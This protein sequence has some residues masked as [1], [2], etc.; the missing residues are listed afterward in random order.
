MES[1]TTTAT[2]FEAAMSA[3]Q[4]N[5][6]VALKSAGVV[7]RE[8]RKA[9]AAAVTGQV[10]EL[11]RALSGAV[12]QAE[13][14]AGLA[15]Q[16]L[17]SFDFDDADYLASGGYVKELLALAAERAVGLFEEDERLL[18]YPSVVRIVPGDSAVEIDRKRERRLRPSVLLDRLAAAQQKPSRFRADHLMEAIVGSYDLVVARGGKK[19]DAVVRLLDIWDVLTLLPGQSRAYTKQEFARDLYLLDQSRVMQTRDGRALRWHA[20]SGTRTPGVLTT[21]SRGGQRQQYW[22]VSFTTGTRP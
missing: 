7:T 22:G 15:R 1:G 11:R 8:L 6:E 3:A 5:A 13:E 14:A 16:A 21:V 4:Q 10:R 2:S 17:E 18:C 20:S 19:P 12:A 9:R